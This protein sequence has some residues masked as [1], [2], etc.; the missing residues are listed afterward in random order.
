[1]ATIGTSW[2]NDTWISSGG[3][4]V[5]TWAPAGPEPPDD[6]ASICGYAMERYPLA[7]SAAE[8]HDQNCGGYVNVLN[9][10]WPVAAEENASLRLT[11]DPVVSAGIA[12]RTYVLYIWLDTPASPVRSITGT[13]IDATACIV[14]FRWKVDDVLGPLTPGEVYIGDV[15]RTDSG[16]VNRVARGTISVSETGAPT[17]L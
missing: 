3:W 16:F 11:F 8:P 2:A 17:T 14:E 15:Y 9:Q 4:R 7:G 1:M 12:G 5:D 13:V 10:C 6:D